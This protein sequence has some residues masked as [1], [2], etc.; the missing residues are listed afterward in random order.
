LNVRIIQFTERE[1]DIDLT[2]FQCLGRGWSKGV[3]QRCIIS[4]DAVCG[5]D[6]G[7]HGDSGYSDAFALELRQA[8]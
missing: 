4:L 2:V 3:Q 7:G 1:Y 6:L 8:V 5:E